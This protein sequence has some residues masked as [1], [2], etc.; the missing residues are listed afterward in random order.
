MLPEELKVEDSQQKIRHEWRTKC[1]M[2]NCVVLTTIAL[3]CG[4]GRI[5]QW[6]S[7]EKVVRIL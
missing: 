6:E 7:K 5:N 4:M 2:A 3:S 1:K